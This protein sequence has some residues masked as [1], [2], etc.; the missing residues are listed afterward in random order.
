MAFVTLEDLTG[1]VE[2]IVFPR[3]YE[4]SQTALAEEN[5]IFIRGRVSAEEDKDAKLIC[6]EVTLFDDVPRELWI[7]FDTRDKYLAVEK[8]I[9][10]MIDRHGGRDTVTVYI[11]NPR[12]KKTFGAGYGVRADDAL[13]K[14]LKEKFGEKNVAVR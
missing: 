8:D 11:A 6:Q 1:S 3:D 14:E 13:V 12:M 9:L 10:D 7:R 4:V 2:V 5:K